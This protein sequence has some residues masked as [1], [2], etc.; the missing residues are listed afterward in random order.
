MALKL[1]DDANEL[2]LFNTRNPVQ[3]AQEGK[4]RVA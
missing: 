1:R 4:I 3:R 2:V